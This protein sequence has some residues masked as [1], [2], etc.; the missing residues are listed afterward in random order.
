MKI[1][2]TKDYKEMSRVGA[3]LIAEQILKK[4]NSV[5][6]LPTGNTPVGTYKELSNFYKKKKL[7][8]RNT[9]TF[10]LDEY[11]GISRKSPFSY[12]RFMQDNFFTQ[13]DILAENI[14]IPNC[15]AVSPEEE[16]KSY[17]YLI[18]KKQ[19]D[20]ALLGIGQN[21]HIG[22]NEPG[23]DP[24]SKTHIVELSRETIAVNQGP[25]KA[26]TMGISTILSAK[27][28]VLLAS[29]KNKAQTI[30]E[31][32]EEEV[33]RNCPASYL[34]SHRDVILVLDKDAASLLDKKVIENLEYH[35]VF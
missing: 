9:T 4:L 22:F 34:Q 1:I 17:D 25:H 21:G 28:I 12:Y 26:I 27:K 7:S 23:T 6:I 24:M 30:K 2:I 31:A 19:I 16:C 13:I 29:G 10:N 35:N 15:E 18:D 32:I 8:F 14:N 3:K 11:L 5:L 33:S 20:L